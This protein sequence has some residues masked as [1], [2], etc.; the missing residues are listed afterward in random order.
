MIVPQPL[1]YDHAALEPFMSAATL[2]FHHDG[3]Y[4]RYVERVN[5]I[6]KGAFTRGIDAYDQGVATHNTTL[7]EQAAQVVAHEAFFQCMRPPGARDPRWPSHL[8][9]ELKAIAYG[10][11]F[12]DRWVEAAMSVF[13]SGWIYLLAPPRQPLAI[14][15]EQGGFLPRFAPVLVMDVWEHAYYLDQPDDRRTY[16]RNWLRNLADWSGVANAITSAR[17]EIP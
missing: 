6:T 10:S 8:R 14:W 7:R 2:R 9:R 15:V 12:E 4:V 16:V 13:G 1:P 5:E 11:S 17:Q 3:H